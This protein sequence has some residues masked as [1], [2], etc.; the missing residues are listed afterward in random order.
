LNKKVKKT[1]MKGVGVWIVLVGLCV[2][3]GM[4]KTFGFETGV[5]SHGWV[6]WSGYSTVIDRIFNPYTAECSLFPYSGTYQAMLGYT[7][8]G[9]LAGDNGRLCLE[10]DFPQCDTTINITYR[11]YRSGFMYF[12]YEATLESL[13]ELTSA[14]LFSTLN[15]PNGIGPWSNFS[16]IL[17]SDAC[18]LPPR[19]PGYDDRMRVCFK[20]CRISNAALIIDHVSFVSASQK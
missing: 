11:T 20:T 8:P 4:N 10:I 7:G 19:T 18:K 6:P 17:C 12:K 14:T 15:A 16:C 9:Y 2:A 13:R 3:F 5:F 1:K